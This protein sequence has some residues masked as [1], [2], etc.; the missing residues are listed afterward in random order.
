[1]KEYILGDFI[2]NIED[3]ID[4]DLSDIP[5]FINSYNMRRAAKEFIN[6]DINSLLGNSNINYII[7]MNF[8]IKM[9]KI[10]KVDKEVES[11]TFKNYTS[12][13][14]KTLILS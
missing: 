14:I 10:L 13:M 8:F 11:I 4:K 3:V 1:M 7:Q 2:S 6:D 9:L 5:K 12:D